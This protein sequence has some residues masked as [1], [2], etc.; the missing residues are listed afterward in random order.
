MEKVISVKNLE[1]SYIKG[2]PVIKNLNLEIGTGKIVGLLGPNGCG[3]TTLMKILVGLIKDHTGEVAVCGLPVG[4]E[5]KAVVSYLP[6]KT[7]LSD[8][9][10]A[11]DALSMFEDFYKDFDKKRA[12][13]LI[14]KFGLTPDMKLKAMSKGMQE[15]MHLILVMS[16]RAK[17][18]ILDEPMS[19]VDPAARDVILDTILKNYSPDSTVLLSTHLIG[20]VEQVFDEIIIMGEGKI[21]MADGVDEIRTKYGKSIDEVFKEVFKC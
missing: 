5:S 9:M 17:L 8:W 19:G 13:E 12:L 20:D 6:E 4:P 18:Y 14:Q 11:S 10:K 16:R 2:H 7:Y 1:K 21:I 3:K 15:K